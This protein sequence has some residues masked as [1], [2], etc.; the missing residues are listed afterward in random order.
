MKYNQFIK[1]YPSKEISSL[2]E[3][4]LIISKVIKFKTSTFNNQSYRPCM[5]SMHFIAS[6]SYG[7]L[8]EVLPLP[9]ISKIAQ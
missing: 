7:S 3:K 2:Y 1:N 5:T 9:L 8:L 6:H 4:L